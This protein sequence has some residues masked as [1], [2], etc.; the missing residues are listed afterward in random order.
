MNTHEFTPDGH[1]SLGVFVAL[2]LPLTLVTIW[3]IIAFQSRYLL[4][5][6][7]F[8]YRLA[9]PWFLLKKWLNKKSNRDQKA[10]QVV[11]RTIMED[12]NDDVELKPNESWV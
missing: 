6:M 9:W 8:I 12:H 2:A 1:G 3:I 4:R 5:D 11:D 7:S 10:R